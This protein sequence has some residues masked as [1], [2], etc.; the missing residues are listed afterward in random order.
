M[1]KLNLINEQEKRKLEKIHRL[2]WK[3]V[4]IIMSFG[5]TSIILCIL[6]EAMASGKTAK[7]FDDLID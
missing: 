7:F 5:F 4:I 1:K 6:L 3:T 2:F